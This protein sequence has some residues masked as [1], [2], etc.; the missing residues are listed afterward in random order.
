M[1]SW[2]VFENQYRPL[3]QV[4]TLVSW[5]NVVQNGT[6][7]PQWE[8]VTTNQIAQQLQA[9]PKLNSQDKQSN[10]TPDPDRRGLTSQGDFITILKEFAGVPIPEQ[11]DRNCTQYFRRGL[12]NVLLRDTG[13]L[14]HSPWQQF[15]GY[16]AAVQ[17]A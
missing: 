15:S 6:S 8:E 11:T 14:E 3:S 17:D 10:G 1:K 9:V 7:V 13:S 12:T 2:E 5:D 4:L 16:V